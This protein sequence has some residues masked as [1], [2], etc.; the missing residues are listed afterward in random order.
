MLLPCNLFMIL[1]HAHWAAVAPNYSSFL[2]TPYLH[3]SVRVS[4]SKLPS[5]SIWGMSVFILGPSSKIIFCLES[6]L[7]PSSLSYCSRTDHSF[8]LWVLL[9]YWHLMFSTGHITYRK[10]AV[11]IPD[12]DKRSPR[13]IAVLKWVLSG[14]WCL[15]MGFNSHSVRGGF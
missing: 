5:F 13:E 7:I 1:L 10:K 2:D 4:C 14:S 6:S 15:N 3:A 11:C 8:F 9:K 12:T